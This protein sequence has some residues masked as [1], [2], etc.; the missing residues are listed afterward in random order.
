MIPFTTTPE[1]Q[2]RVYQIAAKMSDA[3]ISKKFIADAVKMAVE[4]EGMHDL[5]SLWEEEIEEEARGEILADIQEEID[6]AKELPREPERKPYIIFDDLDE[7]VQD[8]L[9]FKK[10]LRIEVDRWGGITKLSE[11]T[12]IPQPSL[13]R[14]FNSASMPRRTTLFRIA[15]ALHL[16]ETNI[17]SRWAA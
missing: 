16:R 1:Q 11:V 3:R 9:A 2:V 7:I 6:Q 10:A 4:Y 17:L 13:S 15:E 8:V 5:L 12:G 14:F